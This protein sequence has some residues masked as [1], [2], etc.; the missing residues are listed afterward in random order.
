MQIYLPRPSNPLL[1]KLEHFTKL[2]PEDRDAALRL[3]GEH[4]Q[5][6]PARGDIARE[7]EAPRFVRIVIE[8]WAFRYKHLEDG[9]RQ[10]VGLFVPGDLCDLNVFVLREMDHF[11]GAV[12]PVTLAQVSREA[13]EEVTLGHPRLLQ[14]LW[15]DTLVNMAILREWVTNLGT[16]TAYERIAHLLCEVFVRLR[17]AGRTEGLS[18]EFPLTQALIADITGLSTVHVSRTLAEIREAGLVE[19]RD[20]VLTIRDLDALMRAALFNPDY[21]HLGRDGRSASADAAV[22]ESL[23]HVPK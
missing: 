14:A 13:F 16:R 6:F 21:L 5:R 12:T 11:I 1:R 2:A 23:L 18:C 3:C 9:R 4:P 17:A 8:G 22:E 15:W 7:G 10:V 19:I 20:R